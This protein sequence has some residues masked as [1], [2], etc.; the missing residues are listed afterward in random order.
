VAVNYLA[1]YTIKKKKPNPQHNHVS[2]K[3]NTFV[4][5]Y[6]GINC[7]FMSPDTQHGLVGYHCRIPLASDNR[8]DY[9][10]CLHHISC[11][12][13]KSLYNFSSFTGQDLL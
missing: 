3:Q 9:I 12:H 11:Q 6:F 7:R 10:I 13:F 2:I 5:K 4:R 8:V 1:T